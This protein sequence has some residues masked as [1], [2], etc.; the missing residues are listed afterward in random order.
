MKETNEPQ[1]AEGKEAN[2][3]EKTLR[4][5]L[6]YQR[7]EKN[8]ELDRVIESVHARYGMGQARNGIRELTL[9]EMSMLAAAGTPDPE[10]K[11][12]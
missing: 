7:F 3:V 9:D 12:K 6:D 11:K 1:T 4:A 2:A 5:L 10:K 8:A